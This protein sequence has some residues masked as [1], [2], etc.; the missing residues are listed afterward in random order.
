MREIDEKIIDVLMTTLKEEINYLDFNSI[1]NR[2]EIRRRKVSKNYLRE[3][4]KEMT[5]EGLV[6]RK[7]KRPEPYHYSLPKE[8]LDLKLILY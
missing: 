6:V 8:E 7:G 3:R 1:Y 5:S 4:L 2:L